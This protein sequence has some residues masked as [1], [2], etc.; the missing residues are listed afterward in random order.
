MYLIFMFT[1][2][3]CVHCVHSRK[4]AHK[5]IKDN[6]LR[7]TQQAP[8]FAVCEHSGC[9]QLCGFLVSSATILASLAI[10]W[11]HEHAAHTAN[12]ANTAD[13]L[14]SDFATAQHENLFVAL[15]TQA[16][17]YPLLRGRAWLPTKSQAVE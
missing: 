14:A 10:F 7:V 12:T 2:Y 9:V 6:S 15:A 16:A 8:A 3:S 5:S 17:T 1:L 13:F 4:V 11:H